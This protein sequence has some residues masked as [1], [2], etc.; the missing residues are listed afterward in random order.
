MH[1]EFRIHPKTE[2]IQLFGE[3]NCFARIRSPL[4]PAARAR[5]PGLVTMRTEV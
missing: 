5:R 4:R 2:P 1:Y 3:K